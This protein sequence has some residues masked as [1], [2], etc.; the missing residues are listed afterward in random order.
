[1]D[2]A[3]TSARFLVVVENEFGDRIL[4]KETTT[5]RVSFAFDSISLSSKNVFIQ[6]RSY[7]KAILQ[8]GLSKD[9]IEE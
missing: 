2:S 8:L 1:M 5:N 9:R 7:P 4:T 6:V 3:E